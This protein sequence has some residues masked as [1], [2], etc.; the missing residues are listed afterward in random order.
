MRI[1]LSVD[2]VL[3]LYGINTYD[4]KT[5]I[6]NKIAIYHNNQVNKVNKDKVNKDKVNEVNG[7]ETQIVDLLKYSLDTFIN[8]IK[9]IVRHS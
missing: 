4:N 6:Y 3:E 9:I 1:D 5:T 2:D 8:Y 7:V